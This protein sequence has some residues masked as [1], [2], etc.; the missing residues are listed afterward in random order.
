MYYIG[1]DVHK[2]TM[3]YRVK[4]AAGRVQMEGKIGSRAAG[5]IRSRSCSIYKLSGATSIRFCGTAIV[6]SRLEYS[7]G[8]RLI[9]KSLS[10][11]SALRSFSVIILALVSASACSALVALADARIQFKRLC[12]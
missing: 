6:T 7:F 12:S 2:R 3:S 4:D 10:S 8:H 11:F 1:L 9:S 5:R